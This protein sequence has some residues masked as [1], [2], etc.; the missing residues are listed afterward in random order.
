[1]GRGLRGFHPE[2]EFKLMLERIQDLFQRGPN[3]ERRLLMALNANVQKLIDDVAKNGDLVKSILAAQDIQNTQIAD[4]KSQL[5]SIQP[6]QDISQENLDA[7][8]GTVSQIEQTNSALATA[9]PA[10]TP[11]GPAVKP[12][13]PN[14]PLTTGTQPVTH[15]SAGNEIASDA[16]GQ[17]GV[18]P[19]S[20]A[21]PDTPATS[22][23]ASAPA[24]TAKP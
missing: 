20:S 10:S 6:G 12:V 11:A 14:A 15:D 19:T 23:G 16:P 21:Q 9:I 3:L 24:V 13:D 2:L 4:L 22:E 7:I 17:P 5:A 18:D 1:M 8:N